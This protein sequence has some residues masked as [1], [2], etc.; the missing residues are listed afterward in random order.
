MA[1]TLTP[2][3]VLPE[4]SKV[5]VTHTGRS[6]FSLMASTAALTS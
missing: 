5:M 2:K 6:V 1:P 4:A 3:N